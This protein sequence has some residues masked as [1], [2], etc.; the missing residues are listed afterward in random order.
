MLDCSRNYCGMFQSHSRQQPVA[1]G[2][3]EKLQIA[4]INCPL[5]SQWLAG[6]NQDFYVRLLSKLVDQLGLLDLRFF[7]YE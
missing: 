7:V 5:G 4:F 2:E 1:E 6:W 3:V